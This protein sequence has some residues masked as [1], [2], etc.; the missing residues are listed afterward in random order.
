MVLI[1][2]CKNI[3]FLPEPQ[4]DFIFAIIIEE[5]GLFGGIIV[6]GLYF[7]IIYRGIKLVYL[8]MIYFLKFLSL[9]IVISLFVQ[10]FINVGGSCGAF[11]SNRN[12]IATF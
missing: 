10:V 1:K 3:S 5:F 8:L 9:G 11:A 2:A 7:L 6:L 12:N 4:N